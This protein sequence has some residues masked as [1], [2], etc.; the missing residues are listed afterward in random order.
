MIDELRGLLGE[1]L[2]TASDVRES[3]GKDA[4]YHRPAPPDA[5]AFPLNTD[6][7]SKI[8]RICARNGTPM[9]PFGKF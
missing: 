4:S 3:H 9:I 8:V 1:R 6:E 7:V 5:V 2:S